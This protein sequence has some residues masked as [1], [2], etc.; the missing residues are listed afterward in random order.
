MATR[1][2]EPGSQGG[3]GCAG[4]VFGTLG[5]KLKNRAFT[6]LTFPMIKSILALLYFNEW[7]AIGEC[8]K[9]WAEQFCVVAEYR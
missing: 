2:R 5:S 8:I 9:S 6:G 4:L 3:G 7:P 1:N